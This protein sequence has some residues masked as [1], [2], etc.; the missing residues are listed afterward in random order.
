[1][2][3]GLCGAL[4][5]NMYILAKALAEDARSEVMFIRERS[6]AY[7]FSQPCWDDVD[8]TLTREQVHDAAVWF[9]ADW[10]MF[11]ADHDWQPPPWHVDPLNYHARV[12]GTPPMRRIDDEE[13]GEN[14]GLRLLRGN[15]S[16]VTTIAKMQENDFLVVCGVPATIMAWLSGKP[17]AIFPHGSDMRQAAG[18]NRHAGGQV[19]KQ[20]PQYQSHRILRKAYLDAEFIMAGMPNVGGGHLGDPLALLPEL[21]LEHVPTPMWKLWQEPLTKDAKREMLTELCGRFGVDCPKSEYVAFVPSRL[22]I[23]WKGHDRLIHA[24]AELAQSERSKIHF[25]FTGWG[26]DRER[27][28]DVAPP[29]MGT[30]L[31]VAFSKRIMFRWLSACDFVVD[32][33]LMGEYGS[34][35]PESM[36]VGTPVMMRIND[37][38]FRCRGWE[39]PPVINACSSRDIAESLSDIASGSI[40]LAAKGV[41]GLA[42]AQRVHSP[43]VV[44]N[45]LMA[46]IE[47]AHATCN[48]PD[49]EACQA[50]L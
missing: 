27:L 9:W 43:E 1:M 50:S 2:K 45:N 5:N 16:W 8:A 40:D 26:K 15:P 6:D 7:P 36:S 10:N 37:S 38:L 13:L 14:I 12:R 32:Q 11:E 21:R 20:S 19:E 30:F 44:V 18:L 31:P 29:G 4:A 35:A 34:S 42:W 23:T 22:D 33:F 17:F 39:P 24:I 41:E 28:I 49:T 47:G 25:L 48:V 46:A 3:I